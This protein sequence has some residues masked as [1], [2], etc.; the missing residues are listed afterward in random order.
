VLAQ[1]DAVDGVAE[2]RVNWT[3]RAFLVRLKE[4]ADADRVAGV[5]APKLGASA[6][7]VEESPHVA[8]LRNGEP[9]MRSGETLKMS[10]HEAK[11][12]GGRAAAKAS[13]AAG[14]DGDSAAKLAAIIEEELV[15]AFA[16]IQ[17]SY[18]ELDAGFKKEWPPL[19]ERVRGRSRAFATEKQAAAI[20]ESLGESLGVGR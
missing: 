4:G 19:I 14:L 10:Q 12:L 8:S 1:L 7:R 15:A 11:V 17:G 5:V 20:A 9:W 2:S 3:G 6:K 13:G 16:R 18:Q